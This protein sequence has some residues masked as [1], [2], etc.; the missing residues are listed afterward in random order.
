M[1]QSRIM[2]LLND[3]QRILKPENDQLKFFL[4]ICQVQ[5][6]DYEEARRLFEK[7]YFGMFKTQY[8]KGTSQPNLLVD[9]CIMSGR[10]D[11]YAE[12]VQEL[13]LYRMSR[14][15]DSLV[16]LYAY[17]LMEL[18]IPSGQDITT[19]IQGLLKKPKVKD[20]FAM[21]QILRAF[22]EGDQILFHEASAT[23]LKAHEGMAKH[24]A[25]R[26][27][28]EGLLC[29]PAMSLAYVALKRNFKIEID[30]DYF[31]IGYLEYLLKHE[32]E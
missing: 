23:L 2:K 22:V 8:W 27:T 30:N 21:G 15:R 13:N 5:L 11:H 17:A 16:A 31:S 10:P 18:L 9:I 19:W 26:E 29:M 6:G 7:S 4:A 25:L 28:A 32:R 3:Y 20:T 14:R 12:A 24:G 1:E